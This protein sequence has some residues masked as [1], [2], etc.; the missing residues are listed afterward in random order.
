MAKKNAPSTTGPSGSAN[1]PPSPTSSTASHPPSAHASGSVG[2]P[3]EDPKKAARR[4]RNRLAASAFR[5]RKKERLE[6]LEGT[7][8]T[9]ET[10]N[11]N[12]KDEVSKLMEAIGQLHQQARERGM[13]VGP[14]P[15]IPSFSKPTNAGPPPPPPPPPPQASLQSSFAPNN[16][17]VAS[18]FAPAGSQ[19][20]GS[21]QPALQYSYQQ[22]HQLNMPPQGVYSQPDPYDAVYAPPHFLPHQQHQLAAD[23]PPS[24]S[25][26]KKELTYNQTEDPHHPE[27]YFPTFSAPAPAEDVKPTADQISLPDRK[28]KASETPNSTAPSTLPPRLRRSARG[29]N[30][31]GATASSL[32]V[33]ST[34]NSPLAAS[35][36]EGEDGKSLSPDTPI[37]LMGQASTGALP[38]G[39][40]LAA[41]PIHLRRGNA[42][43]GATEGCERNEVR[44]LLSIQ[45]RSSAE[46]LRCD[47][48]W[49]LLQPSAAMLPPLPSFPGRMSNSTPGHLTPSFPLPTSLFSPNS[50]AAAGRYLS[51]PG[52]PLSPFINANG[53]AS[54]FAIGLGHMPMGLGSA[55]GIAGANVSDIRTPSPG[56]SVGGGDGY[57]WGNSRG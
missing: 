7:M 1:S 28:R 6:G 32:G 54:P 30:M 38:V 8:T 23:K 42:G 41:V 19:S 45:S 37:G 55:G 35:G 14:L 21:H 47:L 40:A 36:E 24:H 15:S 33:T 48:V 56:T 49:L 9:L 31:S 51:Q 29:S 13:D 50:L 27:S 57:F 12:L 26:P 46:I 18:Y 11:T 53:F 44:C 25:P 34:E 2:G 22:L 20:Q 39:T 16:G 10:E 4:E 17:P 43:Q 3:D 52:P 5:N